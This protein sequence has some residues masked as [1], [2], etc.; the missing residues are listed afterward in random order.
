MTSGLTKASA[1]ALL[2]AGPLAGLDYLLTI[3]IHISALVR[4]PLLVATFA[5]C[6]LAASRAITVFTDDDFDL[7]E[8][9]LPRFLS[10]PL[11]VLEHLVTGNRTVKSKV[12]V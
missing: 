2:T 10:R 1:L 7:L 4:L 11:L 3:D 5:G 6:Y 12:P 9:A 8:N